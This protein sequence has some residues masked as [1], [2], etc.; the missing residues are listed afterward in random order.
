MVRSPA[1]VSLTAV[2][3]LGAAGC[4]QPIDEEQSSVGEVTRDC[5]VP[6]PEGVEGLGAPVSLEYASESLW[7]W[8][9]LRLHGGGVVPNASARVTSA[10]A[11]CAGGPAL[12]RDGQGAPLTLLA[13]SA[14]EEAQNAARTDG[15]RLVLVPTGGFV[16]AGVGY[17]F[18]DHVL[19]GP[20]SFDAD[21]LGAGICVLPEGASSCDRVMDS[22]G[23][24]GAETVL[25]A[26]RERVLNRGGLVAPVAAGG[27]GT[28]QRA[29]VYGCRGE[30]A[31]LSV[32]TVTG[33]PLDRLTEPEAYQLH[34]D[35]DGWTDELTA[36]SSIVD[37]LG[38][39]TVSRY[40]GEYLMTVL[41]IFEAKVFLRPAKTATG[42][43]GRRI[44]AFDVLPSSF[45]PGGGR[46]HSGLRTAS[47]TL[48]LTYTTDDPRGSGLHL[49][50]FRA[51]GELGP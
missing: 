27:G 4:V 46:E 19:K 3:A 22:A 18:Y 15:R 43:F 51:F 42:G 40:E 47:R 28:E 10:S 50:S 38:P 25:F 1:V 32:C 17:L 49:V 21:V 9:E 29:L 14:A 13:L 23:G 33:A 24:G 45:F 2:V 30:A 37:E 48:H 31:F 39:V 35:F 20:G 26:P 8:E 5:L 44:F 7:I 41:D 36:A 6:A 16:H 11:V 34:N 12:S